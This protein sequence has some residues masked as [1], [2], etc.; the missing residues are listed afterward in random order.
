MSTLPFAVGSP[1]HAEYVSMMEDMCD[2]ADALPDPTP[3]D[4]GYYDVSEEE[5]A[6]WEARAEQYEQY[7]RE[8]RYLDASWEDR[9]EMSCMGDY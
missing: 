1:E 2:A 5:E 6:Y 3:E 9:Y 8:D 4:M 7:E